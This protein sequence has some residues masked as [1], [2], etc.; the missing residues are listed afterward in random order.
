MR[1]DFETLAAKFMAR[2]NRFVVVAQLDGSREVVRAHCAD[3]GRMREL[4]LP[5]SAVHLSRSAKPGRKTA[6]DLRFVEHPA[7]G[8][9]ISVNSQLANRLFAEAVRDRTLEPFAGMRIARSEA[10][11]PA[12]EG[13]P[14]EYA[15]ASISCWKLPTVGPCGWK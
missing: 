6:Y 1:F 13:A 15:A 8:Q 4:L 12:D 5:G 7:S 2:P 10:S 3:P 11:A 14:T 9:L